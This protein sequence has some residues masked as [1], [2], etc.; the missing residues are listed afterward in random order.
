M[1]AEAQAT[2][3]LRA[4]SPDEAPALSA[5]AKRAKAHWGY[6]QTFMQ[7]CDAELNYDREDITDNPFFVLQRE[8]RVVGFYALRRRSTEQAELQALFVEPQFIGT[9]CGRELIEHAK[10]TATTLG[11]RELIIQSDPN[12]VPFYIAAGGVQTGTRES[13]SIPGR[14][15]PLFRISL[16]ETG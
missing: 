2:R 6:S 5:L 4:A 11:F 9:G 13:G 1:A 10:T 12:A 15:L 7:V 14:L 16:S 8:T 3:K